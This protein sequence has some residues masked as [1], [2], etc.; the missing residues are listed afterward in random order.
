MKTSASVTTGTQTSEEA[1]SS[2]QEQM[3]TKLLA[4]VKKLEKQREEVSTDR[5]LAKITTA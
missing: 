5:K 4:R 2:D 3:I 1:F